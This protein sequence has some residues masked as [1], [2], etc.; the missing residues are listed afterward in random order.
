MSMPIYEYRCQ[1]CDNEFEKLVRSGDS[2]PEQCPECE[3]PS[4][5]RLISNTNFKLK[6]SGWYETDYAR[7]DEPEETPEGADEEASTDGTDSADSADEDTD[8]GQAA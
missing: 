5:T 8:T 3:A 6:G 7:D 1:S 4:I 2:E